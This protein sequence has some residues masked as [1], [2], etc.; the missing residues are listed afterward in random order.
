VIRRGDV[1]LVELEPARAG[2]ANKRRPAVVVSNDG[3]NGAA[4]RW[5][6]G[7]ITI[8]PVTTS[9]DRVF[10]FQVL[11]PSA[12]TGLRHDSKAQAEQI[13]SVSVS[14]VGAKVGAVPGLLMESVDEAM[15]LHLGL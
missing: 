5:G 3:A 12:H 6:V 7:V 14:R 2:E 10:D 15:R 8:V 9:V 11:L 13:R 1:R 4:V